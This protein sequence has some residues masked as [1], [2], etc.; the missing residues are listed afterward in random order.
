MLSVVFSTRISEPGH[1]A[2]AALRR[3]HCEG[4]SKFSEDFGGTSRLLG[5]EVRKEK[6]SSAHRHNPWSTSAFNEQTLR[7]QETF[8]A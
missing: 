3:A 5:E 7:L 6:Q 2:S 1:Q 8:L 4:N